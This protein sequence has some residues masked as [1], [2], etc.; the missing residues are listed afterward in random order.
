MFEPAENIRKRSVEFV[1]ADPPPPEIKKERVE[2]PF[3]QWTNELNDIIQRACNPFLVLLGAI[4][5]KLRIDDIRTLMIYDSKKTSLRDRLAIVQG[6]N[7]LDVTDWAQQNAFLGPQLLG[8]YLKSITVEKWKSL[9]KDLK[10]VGNNCLD[11]RVLDNDPPAMEF[12]RATQERV[13]AAQRLVDAAQATF[14]ANPTNATREALDRAMDN[15]RYL[16]EQLILQD[17]INRVQQLLQG[18]E[19][20]MTFAPAWA[21]GVIPDAALQRFISPGAWAAMQMAVG[22]INRLKN[23]SSFTLKELVCCNGA[24][25]HFATLVAY[26]YLNLGDGNGLPGT[27][28]RQRTYLNIN[29]MRLEMAQRMDLTSEWFSTHVYV[30]AHPLLAKFDERLAML[31]PEQRP[32]LALYRNHLPARELYVRPHY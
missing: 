18:Q 12:F 22:W 3:S 23:C 5:I 16:N 26:H 29:K 2:F 17:G 21:F 32:A 1:S 4:A 25:D 6:E 27:T 28:K 11:I 8:L 30:R 13:D 9:A 31:D 19:A 24:L 14:N 10:F 7:A 20:E 15:R